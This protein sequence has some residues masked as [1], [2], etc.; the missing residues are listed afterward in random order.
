[1]ARRLI[2]GAAAS[3]GVM[4]IE[5]LAA[6]LVLAVGMLTTFGIFDASQHANR[7][8]EMHEAEIHLAQA[9]LERVQS[10]PYS[11]V[12]LTSA[13]ATSTDRRDP[14]FYV[15]GSGCANFQWNQS[16]TGSSSPLIVN[17]CSYVSTGVSFSGCS[18]TS[19]YCNGTVAPSRTV[20]ATPTS[21]QY[22]VYDY[23]TWNQDPACV[24]T[25]NV[26][27]LSYDT[28]RVTIEVTNNAIAP[29]RPLVPVLVTGI[30]A[31][32]HALPLIG[33]PNVNN[34]LNN[35]GTTCTDANGNPV[36]P[37]NNGLGGETAN[38]WYL[39]NT[40]LQSTGTSYTPPS[41]DNP[42]MHY[43]DQDL[44]QLG[45]VNG[46]GNASLGTCTLQDISGCPQPDLLW[47]APPPSSISQEYNFS[48]NLSSSTS[49]RVILRDPNATGLTPAAACGATPSN[50]ARMAE[51][52][53]TPPLSSG[54]N[55]TGSGG[56][57]LYTNTL[58]GLSVSVTLCIGVYLET[59]KTLLGTTI[60]DPLNLLGTNTVQLGMGA[61]TMAAWP[62]V[63]TPI[64]FTF[65]NLFSAQA[66]A[67][68]LS[69][70]VRVWVAA[71]SGDDIVVHYDAPTVRSS[72]QINSQ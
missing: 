68:G 47:T 40:I 55:L 32:A 24:P 46:C 27:P 19:T 38:T 56:M 4:L 45:L 60:L 34:P 44:P 59:P 61:Y 13:P 9:E 14:G 58:H 5:L 11:Q 66:A 25:P 62:A 36:V 20:A 72:V 65:S 6:I 48:P 39:T 41:A 69:L 53:A 43:T 12:G 67:A 35:P 16:G 63:P 28:K 54:L 50:D 70:G 2:H 3:D 30:V 31:D 52:W 18:P 17:G 71:S 23:I 26:C 21:P 37:C 33:N 1:M 22:T 42:C 10:L 64:S 15:S 57:T 51:W 49:G 29:Y 8:S 7:I